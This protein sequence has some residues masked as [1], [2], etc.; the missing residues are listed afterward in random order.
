MNRTQKMTG[1]WLKDAGKHLRKEGEAPLQH[2]K[3]VTKKS[4]AKVTALDR[5]RNKEDK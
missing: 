1:K 2:L 3:R 5:L 4:G